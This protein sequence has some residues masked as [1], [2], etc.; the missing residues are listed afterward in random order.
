MNETYNPVT[1]TIVN[2]STGDYQISQFSNR[3]PELYYYTNAA[4]SNYNMTAAQVLELE[5]DVPLDFGVKNYYNAERMTVAYFTNNASA[6]EVFNTVISYD[7]FAFVENMFTH[8][9]DW[10]LHG[11]FDSMNSDQM[12]N[13]YTNPI[14][15]RIIGGD[16]E[17]GADFDL[18]DTVLPIFNYDKGAV[19]GQKFGVRTGAIDK[20]D[21]CSIRFIND[22]AYINKY[23]TI[24]NGTGYTNV[25]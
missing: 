17:Q 10:L 3:A 12:I 5:S 9:E 16:W 4:G 7:L 8:I 18:T 13:G 25:T 1:I 2:W 6:V 20:N 22:V 11:S 21:I 23:Q 15:D 14:V 19:S 24:Y